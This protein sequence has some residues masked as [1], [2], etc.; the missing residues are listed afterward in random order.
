M[1]VQRRLRL[2]A[3]VGLRSAHAADSMKENCLTSPAAAGFQL[4]CACL[5]SIGNQDR[6]LFQGILAWLRHRSGSSCKNICDDAGCF[7]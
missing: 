7:L 1:S 6:P 2:R 5:G 4:Q 3:C